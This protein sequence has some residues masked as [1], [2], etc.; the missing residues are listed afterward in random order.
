MRKCSLCSESFTSQKKLN[1]HVAAVHNYKFLCSDRK[2]GKAFGSLESLRKHKL[3]HRNMKFLCN[4]CGEKYPFASD[5]SSHQA[6]HSQ[7]KICHCTYP[8]CG[9]KYKTKAELNCHYNYRHK[10]KSSKATIDKCVICKK[11]TFQKSKYL[12][13][14][15]K[16]HKEDLPFECDVCGER[17]K[18]HSGH[19]NYM[20]AKHPTTKES[21]SDEF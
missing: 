14:H 1:D 21:L 10:Q 2:C 16:A 12:K 19:L 11:K 7:D 3:H 18:W 8:K 17:F 20:K 13:E 5:L 15:M 4:I 9:R 6:L